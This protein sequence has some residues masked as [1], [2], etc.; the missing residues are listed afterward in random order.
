MLMNSNCPDTMVQSTTSNWIQHVCWV[1]WPSAQKHPSSIAANWDQ[2]DPHVLH[3]TCPWFNTQHF[4]LNHWIGIVQHT[5][6]KV[7]NA[8]EGLFPDGMSYY[9]STSCLPNAITDWLAD[10]SFLVTNPELKSVLHS[11]TRQAWTALQKEIHEDRSKINQ[12]HPIIKRVLICHRWFLIVLAFVLYATLSYPP[13]DFQFLEF[14]FRPASN[15]PRNVFILPMGELCIG[16][17]RCKGHHQKAQQESLWTVLD[18][19]KALLTLYL[20]VIQPFILNMVSLPGVLPGLPPPE[21]Q[22]HI[23][24]WPDLKRSSSVWS[25]SDLNLGLNEV[26]RKLERCFYGLKFTL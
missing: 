26:I 4:E 25:T 21:L 12:S 8:L 13:R 3:L 20:G 1:F 14:L 10:D 22:N 23:F 2:D 24:V 18:K 5:I 9:A 19:L 15:A 7:T 6:L 11:M 17:P 16:W